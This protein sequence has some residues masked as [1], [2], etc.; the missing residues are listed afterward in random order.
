MDRRGGQNGSIRRLIIERQAF[1]RSCSSS[2]FRN[3]EELIAG[4][5]SD[6]IILD[7]FHEGSRIP[8]SN[9]IDIYTRRAR[10][11]SKYDTEHSRGILGDVRELIENLSLNPDE[12][13]RLWGFVKEPNIV[14]AV[15]EGTIAGMILGCVRAK[16]SRLTPPHEWEHLWQ[17]EIHQS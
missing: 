6:Q 5:E 11:L 10:R 12:L 4:L 15:L 16:D 17:R 14:Y 3:R 2:N 9:L 1:I 7:S 8:A 13:V